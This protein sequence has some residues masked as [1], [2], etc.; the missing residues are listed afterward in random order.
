[1]DC[2]SV[3]SM[4]DE[5]GLGLLAAATAELLTAVSFTLQTILWQQDYGCDT[6]GWGDTCAPIPQSRA[7]KGKVGALGR[8]E[9][10]GEVLGVAGP[11]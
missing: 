8:G 7:E 6:G 9:K 2:N 4:S 3:S 5:W 11:V 1:M 10:A